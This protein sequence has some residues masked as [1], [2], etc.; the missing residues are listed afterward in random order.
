M[1][2]PVMFAP[3][4]NGDNILNRTLGNGFSLPD[5]LS[6]VARHQSELTRYRKLMLCLLL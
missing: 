6:D 2:C 4:H 3:G 1:I 5:V